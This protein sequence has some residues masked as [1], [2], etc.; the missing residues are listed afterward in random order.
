MAVVTTNKYP[1]SSAG[2]NSLD[3]V[4]SAGE[5]VVVAL[6]PAV[7]TLLPGN[8][9]C[10]I[11]RKV[12]TGQYQPVPHDRAVPGTLDASNREAVLAAPGTYRVV[13]PQTTADV[14]VEEYR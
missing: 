5:A 7:G 11:Q 6:L 14:I 12:S 2:G 4:V 10:K 8:V 13:V 1:A 3:I 9:G